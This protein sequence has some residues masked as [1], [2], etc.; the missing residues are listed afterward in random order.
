MNTGII[1]PIDEYPFDPEPSYEDCPVVNK[2]IG[3][4]GDPENCFTDI[5]YLK[6]KYFWFD[7]YESQDLIWN[8]FWSRVNQ[9][10]TSVLG[11]SSTSSSSATSSAVLTTIL[12][13]TAIGSSATTTPRD[14]S[15]PIGA[16]SQITTT[17]TLATTVNPEAATPT[18]ATVFITD[19][20]GFDNVAI[21]A[22]QPFTISHIDSLPATRPSFLTSGASRIIP[23]QTTFATAFPSSSNQGPTSKP[24]GNIPAT[25]TVIEFVTMSANGQSTIPTVQVAG[26]ATASSLI[27]VVL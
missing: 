4:Q 18:T 17:S 12:S 19:E 9:S 7:S 26:M 5:D 24:P 11:Q 25:T 10:S 22:G 8:S 1:A 20:I 3:N 21:Q 14:T 16:Q 2:M 13:S 23:A 6:K 15:A 27:T